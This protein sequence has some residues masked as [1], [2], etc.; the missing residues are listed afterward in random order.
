[1]IGELYSTTLRRKILNQNNELHLQIVP[2]VTLVLKPRTRIQTSE[3]FERL[4][5]I[6]KNFAP[7]QIKKAGSQQV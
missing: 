5:L 1:M 4:F 2:E 7:T 3:I 6:G